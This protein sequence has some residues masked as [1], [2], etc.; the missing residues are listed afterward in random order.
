MKCRGRH[1]RKEIPIKDEKIN[2]QKEGEIP[3][4][5]VNQ[6]KGEETPVVQQN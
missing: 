2:Q 1:R 5:S 6:F 4:K 3:S